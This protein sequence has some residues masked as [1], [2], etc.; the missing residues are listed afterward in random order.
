MKAVLS[1]ALI[2]AMLTIASPAKALTAGEC[3]EIGDALD[4]AAAAAGT[5]AESLRSTTAAFRHIER[6]LDTQAQKDAA[7][8]V[9]RSRV[10]TFSYL[11]RLS[12]DITDLRIAL[13]D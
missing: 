4:K 7:A 6:L 3:A 10:M 12:E 1:A 13:C 8:S 2:A 9:E 5:M 11:E